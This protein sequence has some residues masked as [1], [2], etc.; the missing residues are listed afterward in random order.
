[1]AFANWMWLVLLVVFMIVETAT[2]SL[3]TIWFA[4]GALVAFLLGLLGVSVGWQAAVFLI[5]SV[6]LVL[7]TRPIAIRYLKIGHTR[8]NVDSMIG[9]Q[10]VVIKAMSEHQTGQIKVN[11]QVWT[12]LPADGQPIGENMEVT[13]QSVEGV[14]LMVMPL[15]APQFPYQMPQ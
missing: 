10:G 3:T 11:G 6:L 14:K 13:V 15:P 1:M 4:V 2:V 7:F 9:Q 12:A 5:V 8:T